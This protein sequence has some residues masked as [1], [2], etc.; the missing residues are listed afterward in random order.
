MTHQLFK[1][2]SFCVLA[3]ITLQ[4]SVFGQ[5]SQSSNPLESNQSVVDKTTSAAQSADSERASPN[6]GK[7]TKNTG[8]ATKNTGKITKAK[9]EQCGFDASALQKVVPAI[10]SFVDREKFPG[11]VVAVVRGN[12]LVMLDSVGYRNIEAKQPMREDTIFRI[13]SMTKPITSV[14]A[15]MLVEQ[16]KI[17]LNDPVAKYI[18]A[19][20]KAKVF[21]GMEG[22]KVLTKPLDRPISVRD[23]MRHTAGLTYGFFGN[24]EVDQMYREAKVLSDDDTAAELSAKVAAIPLMFQPGTE[25]QY[26]VSVDVL[27]HVIEIASGM[28]LDEYFRKLIFEP[29]GMV[30]TGFFVPKESL[31][32]FATNYQVTPRGQLSVSDSP[33][34]SRFNKNPRMLSG[35][36]GLVSTVMDYLR[37]AQMLRNGGVYNGQQLLTQTSVDAMTRN[38]LPTNAVPIAVGGVKMPGMAFGL[39][40]SVDVSGRKMGR[41]PLRGEYGWDGMASTSFWSTPEDDITVVVLTQLLPFSPQLEMAVRPLVYQAVVE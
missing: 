18:P 10:Q 19:F 25:F 38:Q 12:K 29:L 22:N 41:V 32:R 3:T 14:A 17:D 35:G 33:K 13:Y 24:S 40:L 23:L 39:G 31:P 15:M 7:A 4:A 11:A 5:I 16:G 37:F 27:G 1:T 36:G 34:T 28:G 9:P 6:T 30:D 8:K 2:I 26:S 20:G 21:A